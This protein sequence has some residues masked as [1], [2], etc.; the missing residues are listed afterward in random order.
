MTKS[1]EQKAL[2]DWK[3]TFKPKSFGS[4]QHFHEELGIP[5]YKSEVITQTF[6]DSP[7]CLDKLSSLLLSQKQEMLVLLEKEYAK[8][9]DVNF[10]GGLAHAI[11]IIKETL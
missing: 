11:N 7:K 10:K 1:F 8:A 6:A 3:E 9:E 5:T 4:N 2:E